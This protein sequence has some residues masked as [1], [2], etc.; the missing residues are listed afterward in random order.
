MVEASC[1]ILPR[2]RAGFRGLTAGEGLDDAHRAAAFGARL[3]RSLVIGMV[4]CF[5]I[6]RLVRLWS[7][8]NQAPD[9][10]DPVATDTVGKKACVSDAVEAG[11]QDMDQEAANELGRGQANDLH[12]VAALDAIVFPPEG[13]RVGIGADQAVVRDRDAVGVSAEIART[14]SGPPKGGLA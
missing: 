10:A 5:L 3:W 8:I 14:A 12:P 7:R 9:F 13:H 4:A 2:W 11:W 1:D 6:G